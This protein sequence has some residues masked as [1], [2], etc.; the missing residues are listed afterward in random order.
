[1]FPLRF[2]DVVTLYNFLNNLSRC[3][4]VEVVISCSPLILHLN[5]YQVILPSSPIY[6]HSSLLVCG[7]RL[8][9]RSEDYNSG[10]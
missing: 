5:L 9:H 4:R 1:M 10:P 6:R 3:A 7:L 8:K 2:I